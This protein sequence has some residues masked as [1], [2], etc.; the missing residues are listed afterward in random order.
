M[1]FPRE[2]EKWQ[3]K[4]LQLGQGRVKAENLVTPLSALIST[5]ARHSRADKDR[6]RSISDATEAEASS[7]STHGF[8][9]FF[10]FSLSAPL[11]LISVQP[12]DADPRDSTSLAL[13]AWPP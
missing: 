5:Y 9:L 12:L 11:F 8:S 13:C 4:A 7:N 3:S 10:F 1:W 6:L 2:A